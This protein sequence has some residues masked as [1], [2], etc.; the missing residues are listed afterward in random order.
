MSYTKNEFGRDLA[1]K[2]EQTSDVLEISR[3]A[4]EVYLD[5]R[6]LAPGLYGPLMD[7]VMMDAG[8]E[9]G[10]SVDELRELSKSLADDAS[11]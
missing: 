6:D 1:A 9:F 2:L 11:G 3:W 4:H 7:V 10:M 5:N 8:P